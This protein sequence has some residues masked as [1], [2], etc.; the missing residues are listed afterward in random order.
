MNNLAML[1]AIDKNRFDPRRRAFVLLRSGLRLDLLNPDPH[2][3]TDEDLAAGLARTLRWGGASRWAHPLSV[4][5]HSL[6]VL[7][8]REAEELLSARQAL[9]ELLHDAPEFMLG[10]DCIAPLKAQL[11][12]PFRALERR[13]QAA[14]DI[15]YRL[16]AWTPDEY[17][18]HKHADR[19]A[20]ASEAFHV[21]G[22]SR[23]DMRNALGIDLA[24]LLD[25]PLP[26]RGFEPWE[27]WP[28]MVAERL[29][30]ARFRALAIAHDDDLRPFIDFERGLSN[31][32]KS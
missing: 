22:W 6:T 32:A 28:P 30:T 7:A 8:I 27:P 15:R 25:D 10:W 23:T 26:R 9:R 3:W 24:P 1:A 20:A 14:V 4:A 29:F 16:P 21:V 13:L 18:Q 2:A 12:E 17:A 5:Q 31:A 19:L 11:G